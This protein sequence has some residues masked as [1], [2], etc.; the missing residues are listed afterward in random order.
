MIKGA[1]IRL[2]LLPKGKYASLIYREN[3]LR[4]NQALMKWASENEVAFDSIDVRKK[5][6]Y[7]CRYKVYLTEY[8]I[9]SRKILRDV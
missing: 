6:T 4:S 8:H 2:G 9:E 1:C 3:G 7:I 5:E